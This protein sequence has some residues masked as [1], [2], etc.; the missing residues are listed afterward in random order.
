M[1]NNLKR[2]AIMNVYIVKRGITLVDISRRFGLTLETIL[3]LNPAITDPNLLYIG[4]EIVLP[5]NAT[6]IPIFY[7]VRPG[8][9]LYSIASKF[10]IDLEMLLKANPGIPNPNLIMPG[11]N[12]IVPSPVPHPGVTFYAIQPGDSLFK[13]SEKLDIDFNFL[14]QLN[15][16]LANVDTLYI[17]QLI[18]VP[19][20]LP[21]TPE[22]QPIPFSY[23][24][25]NDDLALAQIDRSNQNHLDGYTFSDMV[26][27]SNGWIILGDTTTNKIYVLNSITGEVKASYQLQSTPNSIDFNFTNGM[28]LTNQ[29][30]TNKIAKIDINTD[31]II[32][33]TT[34]GRNTVVTAGENYIAFAYS[35]E[36]PNGVISVIDTLTNQEIGTTE[37]SNSSIGFM[38]FDN[39]NNN[40][41]LGVQGLS[42]SNLYRY[43]FDTESRTLEFKQ[44]TRDVGSNG[45]DLAVS[46][47][48][49][50]VAFPVGGGNGAGYTIFDIDSTDLNNYFGE[51]R[52]GA[53]PTSAYFSNDS[54][55][56]V[57]TNRYDVKL[58]TVDIHFLLRSIGTNNINGNIKKVYFSRGDKIIYV[59][60]GETFA[61]I[62]R[63]YF[64]KSEL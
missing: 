35:S 25:N 38:A 33:I 39:I 60:T 26:P 34:K 30:A 47:D 10:N 42:P 17:G 54:S 8:E 52:V 56:I 46:N 28:I 27:L 44:S 7:A 31:E 50:H 49:K 2:G 18:Y 19:L 20:P 12:I 51:W 61:D 40:L 11:M 45:Q 9:S 14:L 37:I 41:F 63:L 4:Q 59:G 16:H 22:L 5:E 48:G 55:Y 32:Y 6:P 43:Y 21:S 24:D 13:I 64:Y 36:W 29:A 23:F 62:D 3:N 15:A 53:Y 58:F 1:A 57:A